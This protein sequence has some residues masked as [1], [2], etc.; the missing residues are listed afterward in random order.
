MRLALIF[1]VFVLFG[2]PV[3]AANLGTDEFPIRATAEKY[4]DG[5]V[6]GLRTGNYR[7]YTHDFAPDLRAKITQKQFK[8]AVLQLRSRVGEYLY[9]DY[10][11]FVTKGESTL[12]L[13]KAQF[14]ASKND[15]II[16]LTLSREA[17]IILV[18]DIR[19]NQP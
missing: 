7:L 11:G 6:E 13:W 10:M 8:K 18:K 3:Q 14:T 4:L 9:R 19:F 16:I 12:V 15:M 1:I 5:I 2:A 17:N